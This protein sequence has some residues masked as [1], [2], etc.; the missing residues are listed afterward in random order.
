[1]RFD[2][3]DRRN[4]APRG[5]AL[6]FVLVMCFIIFIWAFSMLNTSQQSQFR[7]YNQI[8]RSQLNQLIIGFI[9]E[10]VAA[11]KDSLNSG[12]M[13]A[14]LKSFLSNVPP[15][16]SKVP[17]LTSS[18]FVQGFAEKFSSKT[19]FKQSGMDYSYFTTHGLS[20]KFV[21]FD[22][23]QVN[24]E[25]AVILDMEGQ[26][27]RKKTSARKTIRFV[28]ITRAE[29]DEETGKTRIVFEIPE[30]RYGVW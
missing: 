7:V 29:I 24:C 13:H 3:I 9:E 6:Y 16:K 17:D 5:M 21:D 15:E 11:L 28:I 23:S 12:V 1:M 25:S 30:G 26:L 22:S 20:V 8:N 27:R 10:A 19:S 2:F 14:G 18:I 4:P